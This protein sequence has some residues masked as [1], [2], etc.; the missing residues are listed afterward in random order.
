MEYTITTI[1]T[2]SDAY[3]NCVLTTQLGE[4]V[5]LTNRHIKIKLLVRDEEYEAEYDTTITPNNFDNC[6]KVRCVCPYTSRNNKKY[7]PEDGETFIYG[8]VDALKI[9]VPKWVFTETSIMKVRVC[10]ITQPDNN[11]SDLDQEMWSLIDTTTI[12]YKTYE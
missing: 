4:Y 11:F 7:V 9:H 12:K 8:Y 2:D 5:D 10:D 1:T 6:E 3:F